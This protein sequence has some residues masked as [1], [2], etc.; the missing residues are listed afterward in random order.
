MQIELVSCSLEEGNLS[1]PLGALCIQVS[2]SERLSL[3]E[4][5]CRLHPYTLE[6]DPAEAAKQIA[7]LHADFVGCSIYLWNRPWFDTFAAE[8]KRLQSSVILFAG[9]TEV[10]AN[11][12]SFDLDRYRFLTLGEGEET[13]AKAI[14]LLA[15]GKE[16]QGPG[17]VTRDVSV[18]YAYPEDLSRLPSAFLS[19]KADALVASNP[20]VLW[21]MTRG[22]PFSC[23]FCFESKGIRSVRSYPFERIERELDYLLSHG[24]KDVF[25]LD[26]TFN[27][28]RERT[29]RILTL[30]A[31]KAPSVHFSF[32]LRAELLDEEVANLFA[33]LD[34]SLQIGLQ[35]SDP[36]VLNA[37]DRKFDP[38]LFS[39]KIELLNQRGIVFG[40]DLIIG[41]PGDTCQTF[42]RSLDY[43]IALKPSNIDIFAL[44][45]LPGTKLADQ[46]R[47]LGL[48]YVDRPPYVI[49]RSKTYTPEE[50][51]KA[52]SLKK[53]CDLFYTKG[54]ACMW[55]HTLCEAAGLRPSAVLKLFVSYC[56]ALERHSVDPEQTDIFELQERFVRALL[57]K[58]G[59][60]EYLEA[61]R[62]FMEL[63]QGIAFLQETGENPVIEI[64]YE[65][66]E[67]ALLDTQSIQAFVRK[68]P[69]QTRQALGI[70]HDE[71][72][73][74]SF[75]E[76]K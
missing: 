47:S 62:S 55:I 12:K 48:R 28:D 52:L 31:R 4:E 16:P 50:I 72:G 74:L 24:V 76:Q 54:Q 36:A 65:L 30:L 43:A 21:E 56:D 70:F 18:S 6:D 51:E 27:M 15:E 14:A 40:L 2:V 23:A 69:R 49:Q 3:D 58:L 22:C 39:E 8:L 20:S 41:L 73:S 19:G 75:V 33:Q 44:S 64:S 26:P 66:D 59:K 53:G 10:T 11:P 7:D 71:D 63:H 61:L 5:R 38:K 32:E 29:V 9:G 42:E 25:V 34:C 13:T 45:L 67:L 35:S 60:S 37:I 57:K 68:H 17:I 46:A 1:F